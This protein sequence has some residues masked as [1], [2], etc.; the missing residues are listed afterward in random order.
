MTVPPE[1]L[2]VAVIGAGPVGL[3]TALGLAH[4]GVPV[5]VFEEDADLSLD[6]KAGTVLTRTLEVLHRYGALPG[7]LRA[8][9]RLEEIGD[10][11]RATN[12][13]ARSVRTGTLVDDTRFPF[14]VNIPQHELEPVLRTA[15]DAR[16]PG[17]LRMNHRLTGFTQKND[18]VELRLDTPGGPR[19][20]R[21][22]YVLACDGGRSPV[23]DLLGIAVSGKTLDE[24][25]MLVD[26]KV[27][28][29][30]ANPRDYPY[31]AYFGDPEEWM[32]LVRQPHCW[33]FLYP[34]AP[35]RPEPTRRELAD[36][37]RRFIGDISGLEVIGTN[38]YTVHQR[39]AERWRVGRMFLVGDAAHLI[40]P[41]WALGL[42]T[43]VLDASNLPWRL[44]WVLRGW[45]GEELL[46]GYESE[47]APVAVQ[48][49]GQMAEA[50]RTYMARRSDGVEAMG[51]GDWGNAFTRSLLGVRLDV[52]G[53]GDWSMVKS[54]SAPGAVRAGDRAPDL[55]LFGHDGM[56][57]LHDLVADGFV[58]LYFTDTRRGP[59]I[60]GPESP[61]LR[62]FA[63]SRWDAPHDSGLR[64]RALFDPGGRVEQRFGVPPDT[65]VLVRPDAHVAAIA[66]FA[67]HSGR[68]VAAELYARAVGRPVPV[69]SEQSEREEAH[70]SG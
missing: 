49:A 28:L 31:L 51:D 16:C 65:V 56:L 18:H 41:M 50:A 53:T 12:T 64:R 38:V 30:V 29:D 2:P 34:L 20:V 60:L 15:L 39:V 4:Y 24:R 47:Q 5:A 3:T 10:I 59:R 62:R 55:P 14:V 46:D 33:R 67:P 17:A 1:D 48:G 19:A 22:R 11:D 42:N 6:T 57:F 54:G 36:K 70:V 44:A 43:G 68:D 61:G 23:R 21:A 7:V 25:Y 66:S 9:L 63:V 13:S 8:S 40:T 58:A 69:A 45:A 32:I 52:D 35:G 37:C 26:L 27:D